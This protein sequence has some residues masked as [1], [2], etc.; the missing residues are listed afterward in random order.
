MV[1]RASHVNWGLSSTNIAV[2]MQCGEAATYLGLPPTQDVDR[3]ARL[4]QLAEYLGVG[5]FFRGN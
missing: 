5:Q 4:K 1:T 3:F 2:E